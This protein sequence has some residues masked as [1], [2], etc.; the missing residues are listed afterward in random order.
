MSKDTNNYIGDI[1]GIKDEN[2]LYF[3]FFQI[4]GHWDSMVGNIFGCQKKILNTKNIMIV[5]YQCLVTFKYINIFTLCQ[6]IITDKVQIGYV[7]EHFL[8]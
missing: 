1:V 3:I 4:K 8:E 5:N 2:I 6:L 7:L